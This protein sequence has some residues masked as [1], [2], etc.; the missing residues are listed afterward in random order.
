MSLTVKHEQGEEK[1]TES[2]RESGRWR[3][4]RVDS[5]EWQAR[6]E[7]DPHRSCLSSASRSGLLGQVQDC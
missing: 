6:P 7:G 3:G 5:E 2:R 1:G 4:E